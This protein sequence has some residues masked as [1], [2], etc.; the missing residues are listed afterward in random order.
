ME[1]QVSVDSVLV[2]VPASVYRINCEAA[3]DGQQ[4]LFSGD[5]ERWWDQADL[6]KLLLSS[7]QLTH[8]SEDIRLLPALTVLDV[9]PSGPVLVWTE[10]S[11][12][13]LQ[14]PVFGVMV[15]EVCWCLHLKPVCKLFVNWFQPKAEQST[16]DHVIIDHR[17]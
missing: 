7:N 8:L 13:L 14:P 15:L 10:P 17:S 12:D 1:V 16:P 4:N 11:Q 2:S 3:E 5:S 6:T 9:S